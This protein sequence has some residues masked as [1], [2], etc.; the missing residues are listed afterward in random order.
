MQTLIIHA[1]EI[2]MHVMATEIV[3]QQ[4]DHAQ[5]IVYNAQVV[6]Q[7]T[8]AQQM[9]DHAQET[10]HNAQAV[11]QHTTAQQMQDHAQVQAHHADAKAV[12]HYLH[13]AYAQLQASAVQ[14]HA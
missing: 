4:P 7:H 13:A 3:K 10:A 12:A 11:E 2:V 6:E 1:Q 8:I 5:A 9:Q 14:E